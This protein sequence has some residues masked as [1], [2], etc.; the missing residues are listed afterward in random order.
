MIDLRFL[1]AIILGILPVSELRG[2]I[3]LAILYAKD[4]GIPIILAVLPVILANIL[5]M[6]FIFYFLDNIHHI[7]LKKNLYRKLFE[8][9]LGRV[10]KKADK[11]EKKYN[12]AGFL[13]LMFFVAVPLPGTGAWTGALISWLLDLDRKKSLLYISLGVL[14]AG[15]I[16]TLAT[17][18]VIGIFS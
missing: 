17:L 15:I 2:G 11:F 4:H 5:I 16:V 6:F 9:T 14:I 18:G 7:L 8:K 3:P 13:A 1:Y 10:Q 12:T